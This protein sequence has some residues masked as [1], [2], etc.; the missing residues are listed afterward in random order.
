MAKGLV[1]LIPISFCYYL[2]Y[3]DPMK[4][5][6]A[7]RF[8]IGLIVGGIIIVFMKSLNDKK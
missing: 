4:L 1:Y 5:G 8:F 3:L 6:F 2:A 7:W